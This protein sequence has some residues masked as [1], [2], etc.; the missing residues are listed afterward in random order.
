MPYRSV[1]PAATT[2]AVGK[3][4]GKGVPLLVLFL[5]AA[6]CVH[7]QTTTEPAF[8]PAAPPE[9]T[10]VRD[11]ELGDDDEPAEAPSAPF[12][13]VLVESPVSIRVR[14]PVLFRLG[15]GLGALGHIDLAPCR[16]EGLQPGYVH[17]HLTFRHTG[18]VVR[19]AVETPIEP[20]PDALACIGEQ[21]EA[22]FVPVFDGGD[23]MLSKSFFVN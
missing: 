4:A 6:G 12:R 7:P 17:V 16:D 10:V 2:F 20:P 8:E 15:A 22:T 23:V 14:E 9:P 13:S 21:I 3:A 11:V 18:R 1:F 5:L 19:A